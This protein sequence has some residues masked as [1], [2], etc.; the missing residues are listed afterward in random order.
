MVGQIAFHEYVSLLFEKL[1]LLVFREV[2]QIKSLLGVAEEVIETLRGRRVV[3]I[4]HG[5]FFQACLYG[6][7]QVRVV[8]RFCQV[9]IRAKRHALPY[10][11]L[12]SFRRKENKR[13]PGCCR[14]LAQNMK[15]TVTI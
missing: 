6:V 1:C 5:A 13:Y 7:K 10:V 9:V 8:E 3:L 15:Y 14:I 11:R 2:L 12:F 4:L